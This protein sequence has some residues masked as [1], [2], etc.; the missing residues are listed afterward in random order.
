MRR[1][2]RS[3][4]HGRAGISRAFSEVGVDFEFGFDVGFGFEFD[5]GGGA[6]ALGARAIG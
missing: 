1:W 3:L 5:F 4:E 2:P 6:E